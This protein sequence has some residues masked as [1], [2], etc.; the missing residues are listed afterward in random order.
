MAV[1]VLSLEMGE[2]R[3]TNVSAQAGTPWLAYVRK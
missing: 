1:A 2:R 3:A